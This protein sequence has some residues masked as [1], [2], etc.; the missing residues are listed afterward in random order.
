MGG[1]GEETED[2]WLAIIV[3]AKSLLVDLEGVETIVLASPCLALVQ[4]E[5]LTSLHLIQLPLASPLSTA[6]E[7]RTHI[8]VP[9]C[10]SQLHILAT[11]SLH[12]LSP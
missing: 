11:A 12:L 5:L 2:E 6:E 8:H 10:H 4:Q 3:I 9:P 7:G 1:V